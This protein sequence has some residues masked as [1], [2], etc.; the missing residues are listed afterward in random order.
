MKTFN[1]K[2]PL[3]TLVALCAA[4][5]TVQAQAEAG[6]GSSEYPLANNYILIGLTQPLNSYL[7]SS[8]GGEPGI[9]YT[10]LYQGAKISFAN[11]QGQHYPAPNDNGVSVITP[12]SQPHRSMGS[13]NFSKIADADIYYGEWASGTDFS[14]DSHMVYYSGKDITRYIPSEDTAQYSIKGLS[15]YSSGEQ[16]S[17]TFSANFDD[18]TFTGSLSSTGLSYSLSGSIGGSAFN[19]SATVSTT[20]TDTTV[21]NGMTSGH[22]FGDNAHQV[23]GYA[24]F[25]N[26]KAKNI[27]F[28]GTKS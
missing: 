18:N 8:E 19:G 10:G 13:F 9:G 15:G 2:T 4:F 11:L 6:Y 21:V 5:S 17:G 7:H 20:G 22:F 1:I 25:S 27:A 14:D 3:A 12:V 28:G 26:D 23:A 16:I 24:E